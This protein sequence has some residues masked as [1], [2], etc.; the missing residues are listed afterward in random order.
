ML[1]A[2]YID[3]L[4]AIVVTLLVVSFALPA[5]AHDYRPTRQAMIQIDDAGGA[6]LWRIEL[7]GPQA[8][9]WRK[10]HV[11][12]DKHDEDVNQR[13]LLRLFSKAVGD[14]D[15][16]V[17]GNP[18]RFSAA[19]VKIEENTNKNV[20]VLGLMEFEIEQALSDSVIHVTCALQ[21]DGPL[22]TVGAQ[23]L[24]QW[25]VLDS[26]EQASQQKRLALKR[27]ALDEK[28]EFYFVRLR[29]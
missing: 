8:E 19:K 10:I 26:H 7:R 29:Q 6:V 18:F 28:L 20:V 25:R 1:L 13:A 9:L 2:R 15:L 11:L 3:P 12:S 4:C 24:G 16:S 5:R 22:L 27:V 21:K 23:A 14:I 17:G